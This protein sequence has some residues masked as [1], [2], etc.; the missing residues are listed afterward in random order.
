[1]RSNILFPLFVMVVSF[2]FL[3]TCSKENANDIDK[4]PPSEVNAL[5]IF[6][7]INQV[8]ISWADPKN[9]DFSHVEIS[10][11]SGTINVEKSIESVIIDG[12]ANDSIYHFTIQA[13]DYCENKSAGMKV[14]GCPKAPPVLMW[15]EE[16]TTHILYSHL[17][18][19]SG[20]FTVTR[21]FLNIGALGYIDFTVRVIRLSDLDTISEST[22]NFL[23][24][25]NQDYVFTFIARGDISIF[26]CTDCNTGIETYKVDFIS[27]FDHITFS[28]IPKLCEEVDVCANGNKNRETRW[29]DVSIK[30]FYLEKVEE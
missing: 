11:A 24:E 30:N 15:E 23:V 9:Y 27:Q 13:V 1:M 6:N 2:L 20:G 17:G 16:I 18:Y 21:P 12:L 26:N 19:A 25:E 4:K 3:H 28:A 29:N 14:S 5:K 8:E 10:W 7:G 22:K